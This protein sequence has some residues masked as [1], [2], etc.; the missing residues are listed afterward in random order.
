MKKNKTVDDYIEASETWS[1]ELKALHTILRETELEEGLKWDAPCYMLGGKNIVGMM[2]FKSYFGLWFH[3]GALLEDKAGVLINA[4]EG[5]TH[6]LRQWRMQ[7]MEEIKPEL[8]RQ[9]LD[10]AIAHHKA[11]RVVKIPKKPPLKI[12]PELK[13]ALAA[14][15]EAGT[16][17]AAL[18]PGSRR[19]FA[20]YISD[21]KQA[22]TKERRL[23]KIL[24]MIK[25][26]IGLN[27]KYK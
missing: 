21:A 10:E 18:K 7:A 5:K 6:A 16:K 23:A 22:A 8:I 24:P 14:D 4:Q 19:E 9:Y 2:A 11:G 20:E 1:A 25:A 26:G 12:P 27:D 13:Q 3:Q 17:F 15:K